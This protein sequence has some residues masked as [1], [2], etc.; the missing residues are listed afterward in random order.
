LAFRGNKQQ[1]KGEGSVSNFL[2]LLKREF[3]RL[4]LIGLVKKVLALV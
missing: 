4:E 3:V 2:S 1:K